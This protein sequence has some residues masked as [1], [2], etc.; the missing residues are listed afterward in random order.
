VVQITQNASYPE[1]RPAADDERQREEGVE[2]AVEDCPGR[3]PPFLAIK[4]PAHPYKCATQNRFT[5]Q[6][7]K[8]VRAPPGGRAGPDGRPAARG[9]RRAARTGARRAP[10]SRRR[11]CGVFGLIVTAPSKKIGVFQSSSLKLAPISPNASHGAV[12]VFWA[13]LFGRLNR[14]ATVFCG[15]AGQQTPNDQSRVG[16]YGCG[17]EGHR[18]LQTH[19]RTAR[20]PR[21]HSRPRRAPRSAR[22][23]DQ[24]RR[25]NPQG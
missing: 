5:V 1:P 19:R 14:K 22:N 6:N 17:R 11:A 4:R 25:Q 15:R 24:R 21:R 18:K 20:G 23:R 13:T 10:G 7:A 9:R 8:A 2:D 16:N 12:G 3:K